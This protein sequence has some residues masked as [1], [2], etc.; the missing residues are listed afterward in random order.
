MFRCLGLL[1]AVAGALWIF[2]DRGQVQIPGEQEVA[3]LT[4]LSRAESESGQW[5]AAV[6]TATRGLTLDPVNWQLYFQRAIARLGAGEEHAAA[7]ADFRRALYLEPFLGNAAWIAA[8]TWA[9]AGDPDLAVSDLLEACRRVPVET[10]AYFQSVCAA[11]GN[12]PAFLV[13]LASATQADPARHLLYIELLPAA[14]QR[15]EVAATVAS[16]PDLTNYRRPA[17]GAPVPPVVGGRRRPA[18]GDGKASAWQSSGWRAWSNALAST[19]ALERACHV[20]A[21]FSPKPAI[22]PEAPD[23]AGRSPAELQSAARQSP[24]DPSLALRLYRARFAAGDIPGA[25]AA[26]H[27]ITTRPG[28]PAYFHYLEAALATDAGQ[29]ATAW[30]AWTR[31]LNANPRED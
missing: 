23:P 7:Q 10:P 11:S 30:D 21:Q 8:M 9:R 6:T 5:T 29:W 17:A 12:D 13:R 15:Q 20:A 2:A 28:C 26:L 22:P 25:L 14:F 1:L 18:D 19:G 4:T 27:A 24:D 31:Y 16:D 3:R